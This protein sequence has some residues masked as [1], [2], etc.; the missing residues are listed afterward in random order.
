MEYTDIIQ[1]ATRSEMKLIRLHGD[2]RWRM[3]EL[4]LLNLC[5]KSVLQE[6]NDSMYEPTMHL[7]IAVEVMSMGEI[8]HCA[9]NKTNSTAV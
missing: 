7:P 3:Q 8:K 5:C 9:K 1:T 6:V 4:S 2:T